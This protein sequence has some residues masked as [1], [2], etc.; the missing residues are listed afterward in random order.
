MC[1]ILGVIAKYGEIPALTDQDLVSMRDTMTRRGPDGA[2]MLK[3][4]NMALAHRRLAIRDGSNAG[5]Q[6]MSTPDGRYHLVYNGEL[7]NDAELRAELL[8]IDAVPGGFKSQCDTETVLYA[9]AAWGTAA[10]GKLRGMFAIGIYDTR[11]QELHIARDPLGVKPLYYHHAQNGELTF[12]SDPTAILRHP[13]IEPNPDLS[14][15]SAYMT[16]MR[17][18]LGHRTLFMGIHALRPGER[19]VFKAKQRSLDLYEFVEP[20]PAGLR[21]SR[22]EAADQ[23]R[24]KLE[25]SVKRHLRSD[26]PVC[27]LLS[28]GLDST[29]LCVIERE[30]GIDLSTW[31]A[32][33]PVPEGEQG[34]FHFARQAATSLN[35][36]HHEIHVDRKRFT[37]NWHWM[38]R[39]GGL[40]LSTPNEV[41][42]YSI[43]K[44]LRS[45]GQVV[46]ISGEGADELFGGYEP[47]LQAA[48]Q[49]SGTPGD[50]RSGGRFQLDSAAWVSPNI[51]PQVLS[52][53]AW[54]G[55]KA[56][57]FLLEHYD[58]VFARARY[59]SGPDATR[60]DPF[61]R[62]Q[63]H[64]NLTNLLQRLDTATMLASVEGRTPFADWDVAKLAESLPMNTKFLPARSSGGGG[65]AL[66]T[67]V[68]QGKLVLRDAWQGK[69]PEAILKRPKHSFPLPFEQWVEDT[70]WRLES[71]PFAHIVFN[72]KVRETVVRDPNENWQ[73]AWPMMNLAL[74]GD[75]WWA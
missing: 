48:W 52:H 70:G 61:L 62:F 56:D 24:S 69:V 65:T 66:A 13:G 42:I 33:G 38:V 55:A 30:L 6:P 49:F 14:M 58:D 20:E 59:E 5:R 32:G 31:C 45:A 27:N 37:D 29:I 51:K 46:A 7:Y 60:L 41:A 68:V 75:R 44:E 22:E 73:F 40:P 34:D 15:I 53:D 18:T 16:T 19:G 64:N 25:D 71:S 57:G 3:I 36:D 43:A 72:E 23:V 47:A 21:L 2:G 54:E 35:A 17:S 10:F 4:E 11:R 63:R 28:G 1:G 12:A 26:V 74:W 67:R 8:R 50:R 9:F 39:E